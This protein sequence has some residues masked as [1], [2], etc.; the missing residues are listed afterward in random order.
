MVCY[1]ISA[2]NFLWELK[3]HP[4]ISHI[5]LKIITWKNILTLRII[6][7]VYT[8][9]T[10]VCKQAPFPCDF[11]R[12]S[13]DLVNLRAIF[14]FPVTSYFFWMIYSMFFHCTTKFFTVSTFSQQIF[15]IICWVMKSMMR[16]LYPIDRAVTSFSLSVLFLFAPL[17]KIVLWY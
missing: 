7:N 15:M 8:L 5:P 1:Y 9:N 12:V 13:V 4:M 10:N 17:L 16:F 3:V 2:A 14:L 6:H 11:A